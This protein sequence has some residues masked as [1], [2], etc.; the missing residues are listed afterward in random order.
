MHLR[1]L[2]LGKTENEPHKKED[3]G[4]NKPENIFRMGPGT[5]FCL[6]LN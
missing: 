1:D 2:N 3:P 4:K 6:D 5:T